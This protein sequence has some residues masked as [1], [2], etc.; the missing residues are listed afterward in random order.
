MSVNLKD[1]LSTKIREVDNEIFRLCFDRRSDLFKLG[2]K[3]STPSEMKIMFA[4]L[5]K[6]GDDRSDGGGK[7]DDQI[8]C[9]VPTKKQGQQVIVNERECPIEDLEG[10]PLPS[11]ALERKSV[12]EIVTEVD[13]IIFA[14]DISVRGR[15][16][17]LVADTKVVPRV[18]TK[19]KLDQVDEESGYDT[20]KRPAVMP[21]LP[22]VA[23]VYI[24]P[25]HPV[26]DRVVLPVQI[27]SV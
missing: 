6:D 11:I 17:L 2:S 15:Y 4:G 23:P 16:R 24:T 14:K 22:A 18:M 20:S 8:T 26:V 7:Y 27:P 10:K 1:E 21:S 12:K 3:I 25:V 9:T 19:R 5:V 13:K